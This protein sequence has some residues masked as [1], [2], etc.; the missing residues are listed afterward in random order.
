M[1]VSAKGFKVASFSLVLLGLAACR[2]DLAPEVPVLELTNSSTLHLPIAVSRDDAEGKNTTSHDLDLGQKPV[3]LTF[4]GIPEGV[5][6]SARVQFRA[7]SASGRTT[8]LTITG[9]AGKTSWSVP[10]WRSAG[11]RGADQLTPELK[12]LVRI[13]NGTLTLHLTGAGHREAD[14]Y[15]SGDTPP[16]LLLSYTA[17]GSKGEPAPAP[18]PAPQP[19]P[20]KAPVENEVRVTNL[21]DAGA[22]SL[23]ACVEASSGPRTCTFGVA[24]KIVLKSRLSLRDTGVTLAGETAPAPG[25]TLTGDGSH[26]E[27][28]LDIKASDFEVRHLRFRRGPGGGHDNITIGST[29]RDGYLHHNSISWSTDENINTYRDVHNVTWAYNIIAEPLH[30]STHE[31]GCHGKNGAMGKYE[32]GSQTFYKNLVMSAHDRNLKLNSSYGV[33]QYVNNVHYNNYDQTNISGEFLTGDVCVNVVGNTWIDGPDSTQ[34]GKTPPQLSTD[35]VEGAGRLAVYLEGNDAQRVDI[36]TELRRDTPCPTTVAATSA[37][38]AYKDVLENAGAWPR[39]ATDARLVN[40]VKT[41]T[42]AWKNSVP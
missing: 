6:T 32:T 23:R 5:I 34:S 39:D 2:G 7:H 42:G 36:P 27:P 19:P 3:R 12:D 30:C 37:G 40:E 11:H 28:L 13:E 22:G 15:D 29:S 33:V 25:I 10:R 24:G 17:D 18:S 31:K 20:A 4:K 35:A 9:P 38:A 21:N 16:T 41:N 1:Q 8:T 26:G 14:S